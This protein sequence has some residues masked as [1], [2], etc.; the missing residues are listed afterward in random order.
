VG[1]GDAGQVVEGGGVPTDH[2][3]AGAGGQEREGD[4]PA[5]GLVG[6]GDDRD[7][8]DQRR[9]R[10]E[11]QLVVG[12]RCGLAQ[13]DLGLGLDHHALVDGLG[14][15][16]QVQL[17]SALV[18]PRER[19]VLRHLARLRHRRD[20]PPEPS[21]DADP[22]PWSEGTGA[23]RKAQRQV[24]HLLSCLSVGISS[25]RSTPLDPLISPFGRAEGEV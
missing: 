9:E 4:G 1:T 5:D 2:A 12:G 13:V 25:G 11:D 16:V 19:I 22:A 17:V 10:V 8:A 20:G 18:L 21:S 15:D 14:Q 24:P 23:R 7:L 6:A 3:D